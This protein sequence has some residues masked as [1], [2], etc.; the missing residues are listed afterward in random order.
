[1]IYP[2]RIAVVL[3]DFCRRIWNSP[4]AQAVWE[5]RIQQIAN[6]WN[7]IERLSVAEG[8]RQAALVS[9]SAEAL[10]PATAWA[11]E[12]SLTLV[13][14]AAYAQSKEY[15]STPKIPGPGEA[16]DYRAVYL[17]PSD[18]AAWMKAWNA[19]PTD[20]STMGALLGYP[21]CCRKF[22]DEVWVNEQCV[23]TTWAM[24]ASNGSRIVERTCS[25]PEQNI[26]LRWLGIRAVPHL[27]CSFDCSETYAFSQSLL[28]CGIGAGY[29]QEVDWMRQI[30][31]WPVEWTALHG[32]AEIRT[33]VVKVSAR[34]DM[35]RGKYT[36]RLLSDEYPE[37]GAKGTVFPYKTAAEM[38]LIQLPNPRN[39]GFSSLKAMRVAHQTLLQA[40]QVSHLPEPT[41]VLDLGAGD[42]ALL[43]ELGK[44]YPRSRLTGIELDSN[45]VKD[46]R[47]GVSIVEADFIRNPSAWSGFYDLAIFM[48][49]RLIECDPFTADRIRQ[50][51]TERVTYVLVYAYGDWLDRYKGP[52][53]LLE[54]AFPQLRLRFEFVQGDGVA[55][56]VIPS[57]ALVAAER[58]PGEEG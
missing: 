12:H 48:P 39:N 49:G 2:D 43:A 50:L 45:R 17:R 1:M 18:V 29:I 44:L 53:G 22:F 13:P 14:L 36:V 33:P 51:L 42:G 58:I 54:A 55:A 8:R 23:D 21:A 15:S 37:E 10:I 56:C 38:K 20:N 24:A 26:L 28:A 6:A 46:A 34:T 30:L 35:T 3:P 32:I 11:V 41:T 57:A 40:V 47:Q 19:K 7:E 27:P 9:V 5:P 25:K 31:S 52:A 4:Q 16:W